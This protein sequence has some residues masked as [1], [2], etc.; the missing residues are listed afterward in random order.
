MGWGGGKYEFNERQAKRKMESLSMVL[1][2]VRVIVM[3]SRL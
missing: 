1:L 3:E 2:G